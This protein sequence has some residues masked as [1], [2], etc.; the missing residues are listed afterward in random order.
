MVSNDI[1][2]RTGGELL[3]L[4]GA[5]QGGKTVFLLSMGLCQ[6]LGQ[7]G[8]PVCAAEASLSPAEN[9]LTIFAPNGQRYGRKGLLAEEAGRIAAAVETLS[10]DSMVLVRGSLNS[11]MLSPLRVSTA[12]AMRPA[13]SASRPLR[14]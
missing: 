14:P 4:T 8:F 9:I 10:G 7:L 13:S 11:T 3:I 12:A 2:L 5:N 6:W 1:E